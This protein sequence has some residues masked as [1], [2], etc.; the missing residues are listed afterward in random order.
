MKGNTSIAPP[1]KAVPS[2]RAMMQIYIAFF[3]KANINLGN[4]F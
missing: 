1:R 3:K 4:Y 2:L